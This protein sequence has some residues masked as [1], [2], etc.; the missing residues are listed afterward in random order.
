MPT[1]TM[2]IKIRTKSNTR[3]G[4]N[5]V[6]N[7]NGYSSLFHSIS[8]IEFP[9]FFVSAGCSDSDGIKKRKFFGVKNTNSF[10]RPKN[11]S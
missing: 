4:V 7:T 11:S 2:V 8:K 9:S 1:G 6:C 10:E 5:N 3:I